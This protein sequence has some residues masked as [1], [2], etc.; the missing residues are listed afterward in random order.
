MISTWHI[1]I[2]L[3][4][5]PPPPPPDNAIGSSSPRDLL[6]LLSGCELIVAAS[7]FDVGANFAYEAFAV[8]FYLLELCGDSRPCGSLIGFG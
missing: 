4:M 7:T 2:I 5:R 1:R 3:E 8:R 6:D